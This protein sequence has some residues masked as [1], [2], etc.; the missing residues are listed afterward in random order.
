MNKNDDSKRRN[1]CAP[2]GTRTN[3]DNDSKRIGAGM[4][5]LALP[6]A[7]IIVTF[8]VQLAIHVTMIAKMVLIIMTIRI[9]TVKPTKRC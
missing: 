8:I 7:V 1:H 6:L 2:V 3:I 4:D 5:I 9:R